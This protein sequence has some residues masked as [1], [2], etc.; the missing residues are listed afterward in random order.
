MLFGRSHTHSPLGR[1]SSAADSENRTRPGDRAVWINLPL[2]QDRRSLL[3]SRVTITAVV[4]WMSVVVLFRHFYSETVRRKEGLED[5]HV[6]MSHPSLLPEKL[7][8]ITL[9]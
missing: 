9:A 6:Y 1:C 2:S 4:A 8:K 3:I 7:F 5:L